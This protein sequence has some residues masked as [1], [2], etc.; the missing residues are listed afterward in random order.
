MNNRK[1]MR[2]ALLLLGLAFAACNK[3]N[4]T[5]VTTDTG[6]T[7][8]SSTTSFSVVARLGGGSAGDSI[9]VMHSCRGGQT[10]VP[11]AE[12]ALPGT[13]TTYLTANYAGYTFGKAFSINDTNS[14]VTGYVVVIYYNNRPVALEF[15]AS[16]NFVKVLEQ[17]ERGDCNGGPGNGGRFHIRDGR[18]RDTIALT[19]L[20]PSVTGYM[21]GNYPSDTLVK[22]FVACD[23]S[24]VVISQNGSIYA[25]VFSAA[26]TF[27]SRT[28][29]PVHNGRG[30]PIAQNALPAA[31]QSYLSTTY[32]NAVFYK[33]FAIMQGA[34][35]KGYVVIID[36]NN[37]KYALEFDSA[38]AFV[39]SKV[40]H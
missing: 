39:R 3:N 10:R 13:V 2:S 38:G 32:P 28:Q 40:I 19:A 37:T 16:G 9:Y 31:V 5:P 24:I 35:V 6:T 34:T 26:G 15:D 29:V 11:V 27:I 8:P 25:T 36:A 17:R 12:S 22:A 23:S 21:S 18:G 33:A 14:T 4:L 7:T 30:T 1:V 20:P